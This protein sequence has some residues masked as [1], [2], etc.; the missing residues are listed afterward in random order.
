MGDIELGVGVS[1]VECECECD[2]YEA[3]PTPIC[4]F[5]VNGSKKCT[6]QKYSTDEFDI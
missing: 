5:S 2:Q 1:V 6:F 3:H 4:K